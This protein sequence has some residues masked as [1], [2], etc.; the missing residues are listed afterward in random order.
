MSEQ[1]NVPPTPEA[2]A[3]T[4]NEILASESVLDGR[5][6]QHLQATVENVLGDLLHDTQLK[7]KLM[8]ETKVGF[9]MALGKFLAWKVW[10]DV[11]KSDRKKAASR[12]KP[13]GLTLSIPQEFLTPV[14]ER[15]SAI[16][17]AYFERVGFQ[18][19][20]P[21]LEISDGSWR[22]EI[23]G[24]LLEIRTLPEDWFEPL[25][26]F[27]AD[28][29]PRLLT[30][31]L[32]KQLI[33]E[34]KVAEPVVAEEMERLR[35]PVTTIYKILESLLSESIPIHEMETILTTVILNWE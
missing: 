10:T 14:K 7:T 13:I 31:S 30:L 35:M 18:L 15:W 33:D 28:H 12:V 6:G 29:S 32:V 16:R 17:A 24:G 22:L 1:N 34:V 23:R 8:S 4:L 9:G 19:A 27:L 20:E 3:R 11:E 26:Q 2:L 25:V 5:N 21:T